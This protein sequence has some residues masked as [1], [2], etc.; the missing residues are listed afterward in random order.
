M[1]WITTNPKHVVECSK[2]VIQVEPVLGDTILTSHVVLN[3][4]LSKF[5]HCFSLEYSYF[6]LY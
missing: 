5:S 4:R 1:Y 3:G 6:H 2:Y